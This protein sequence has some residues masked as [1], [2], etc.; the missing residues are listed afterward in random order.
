MKKVACMLWLWSSS[1]AANWSAVPSS[2]PIV[3]TVTGAP[4]GTGT[5]S[6]AEALVA[7]RAHPMTPA[8]SARAP[9]I[10]LR[11]LPVIP[12][13]ASLR[14]VPRSLALGPD[15][16]FGRSAATSGPRAVVVCP[17]LRQHVWHERKEVVQLHRAHETLEVIGC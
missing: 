16:R 8:A 5:G 15:A 4:R 12:T 1:S 17:I 6:V 7:G 2:N 11:R 9:A 3:T 10:A 13:A 14:L